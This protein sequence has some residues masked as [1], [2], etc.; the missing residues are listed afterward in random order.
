MTMYKKSGFGA[1]LSVVLILGVAACQ[2]KQNQN[3][4]TKLQ[5]K[6]IRVIPPPRT[7]PLPMVQRP[8]RTQE[9]R[10]RK[11]P[12]HPISR[13]RLHLLRQHS[14][15]RMNRR[16]RLRPT[17]LATIK[18]VTIKPAATLRVAMTTLPTSSPCM[19]PSRRLRCPNTSS[20]IAPAR[21]ISGPRDIGT[22]RPLATTGY[23]EP[24]Y[25][26]RTLARSGPPDT[27]DSSA[28]VIPGIA[29][30]GA[31]TSAFMVASITVSA[32]S[33]MV[34]R[35]AIGTVAPFTT[36]VPLTGSMATFAMSTRAMSLTTTVAAS[37][38]TEVAEA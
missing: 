32:I 1:M 28:A 8:P 16:P 15:A 19:L 2:G 11:S 21:T 35:A 12:L 20:R 17:R 26:L 34:T 18:A 25:S 6:A 14:T 13:M 24:G 30:I 4:A 37:V 31:P 7:T 29:D 10:N 33:A 9:P 27:G 5:I 3:V 36:T 22:G 38:I 23:L